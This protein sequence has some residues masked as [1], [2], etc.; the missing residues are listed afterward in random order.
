MN[1]PGVLKR[2]NLKLFSIDNKYIYPNLLIGIFKVHFQ[3]KLN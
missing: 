2:N 1:Y 3:R